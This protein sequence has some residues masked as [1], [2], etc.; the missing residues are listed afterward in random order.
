MEHDDEKFSAEEAGALAKFLYGRLNIGAAD[1]ANYTNDQLRGELEAVCPHDQF[2]VDTEDQPMCTNCE[3]L[4]EDV[5]SDAK[6]FRR[7][8]SYALHDDEVAAVRNIAERLG[9]KL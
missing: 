6:T 1:V 3:M 8:L 9:V 4:L 2:E 7:I 5:E